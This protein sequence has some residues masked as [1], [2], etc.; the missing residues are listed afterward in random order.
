MEKAPAAL[1]AAGLID[2]LREAGYTVNDIGDIPEQA[3]RQDDE[4]PRIR[5]V[6]AV[7]AALHALRPHVE[8]AT[9]SGALVLIL[10]GEC[11]IALGTIAGVRRYY[12]QLGLVWLDSDG[13]L[14]VPATS[15]SGCVHGMALAHIAGHG[16]PELVRYWSEPP[17]VREPDIALFG[18]DRLDQPEQ[19]FLNR[20]PMKRMKAAEILRHGAAAAAE[21]IASRVHTDTRGY[22]LHFDVDFISGDDMPA[23]D[24]PGS[25]GIR[26]ADAQKALKVFTRSSHLVAMN[27]ASFNP[28]KDTDGS[29][30]RNLVDLL[31]AVLAERLRILTAPPP[32]AA[33]EEKSEPAPA[34]PE[35]AP[36]AV[37]PTAEGAEAAEESKSIAGIEDPA[38]AEAAETVESG[39]IEPS[40]EPPAADS[41]V[42]ETSSDLKE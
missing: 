21:V 35:I 17:L 31:V 26:I 8:V 1:R 30:A 29:A 16:G 34:E 33:P 7:L 40:S 32:E 38:V 2:R 28:E 12:R 19:E 36:A 23:C 42:E 14:N 11:T 5:N 25:G 3:W 39:A 6:P 18:V 10:G 41:S 24:F 13:D 4:S 27:V 9:K 22:V 20:S 15:P 37:N